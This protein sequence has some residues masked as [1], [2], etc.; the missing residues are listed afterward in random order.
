VFTEF[1]FCLFRKGFFFKLAEEEDVYI[2]GD[3]KESYK[4]DSG[5][6]DPFCVKEIRYFPGNS[7]VSHYIEFYKVVDFLV[8]DPWGI[9]NHKKLIPFCMGLQTEIFICLFTDLFW[10]ESCFCGK[11][12]AHQFENTLNII[13]R[14]YKN[15][16]L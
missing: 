2:F 9:E 15:R 10:K 6:K 12:D 16:S 11:N 13:C 7:M 8:V 14:Q 3:I 1:Y 5:G 4:R